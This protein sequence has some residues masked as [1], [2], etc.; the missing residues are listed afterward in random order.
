M[1]QR[2]DRQGD[3]I[4]YLENEMQR[5]ES[6]VGEMSQFLTAQKEK[7]E[8]EKLCSAAD[9]T[10][11]QDRGVVG[12]PHRK[13]G[14]TGFGAYQYG[15][16]SA[17]FKENMMKAA[18]LLPIHDITDGRHIIWGSDGKPGE[19]GGVELRFPEKVNLK[20]F[21]ISCKP[22]SCDNGMYHIKQ[23]SSLEYWDGFVWKPASLMFVTHVD[24]SWAGTHAGEEY[25]QHWRLSLQYKRGVPGDPVAV[26]ELSIPE[27]CKQSA[28]AEG[29]Y[30]YGSL[31]ADRGHADLFDG[32]HLLWGADG[33]SY[34][35]GTAEPG[36][37]ELRF[38]E[39]VSVKGF[40]MHCVQDE[41][42]GGC[43]LGGEYD[44]N[45]GK[46]QYWS[47]AEKRWVDALSLTK[48]THG[49][50][51]GVNTVEAMSR[52]WRWILDYNQH[53]V[54]SQNG[55]KRV[56]ISELE[57]LQACYETA[58]TEVIPEDQVC[59]GVDPFRFTYV[60][61][62][63]YSDKLGITTG[64]YKYGSL[65]ADSG[66]DAIFDGRHVMWGADGTG[67]YRSEAGKP[68]G[69]E[70]RFPFP[71]TVKGF[72]MHC[73]QD[74]STEGGGCAGGG[75]YDFN[76]GSLQYW[77][78]E[79]WQDAVV[80]EGRTRGNWE[81]AYDGGAM[82]KNWR[83]FMPHNQHTIDGQKNYAH[84]HIAELEITEACARKEDLTKAEIEKEICSGND[85]FAFKYV[86]VV[87]AFDKQA[88]ITSGSY[89]YGV[90]ASDNGRE[91]LYDGHHIMWGND[92]E[93]PLH[94]G[95]TGSPN[96]VEVRFPRPVSVTQFAMHCLQ[97]GDA[98]TTKHPG[99][100]A[101][102]GRYDFTHAEFQYFDKR[103]S[104]W[105][106]VDE[107][108][109]N[110]Y[111][112]WEGRY[113]GEKT[114]RNW[115]WKIPYNP[116]YQFNPMQ[117][118]FLS[119]L[120]L[121]KTC[122]RPRGNAATDKDNCRAI[123]P[124]DFTYLGVVGH[125]NKQVGITQPFSYGALSADHGA[126]MI[127]DGRHLMFGS[128]DKAGYVG[129][130][131]QPGGVEIRFQEPTTIR[132]FVM[133]C[134]K[135]ETSKDGSCAK[136]G[137]FDFKVGFLQYWDENRNRWREALHHEGKT[138]GNWEGAYLGT[139]KSKNWRWYLPHNQHSSGGV[140]VSGVHVSELEITKACVARLPNELLSLAFPP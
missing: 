30:K 84:V 34:V 10:A 58:I 96:G 67:G 98:S 57:V 110:D 19:P 100:F 85:P 46:L 101:S 102:R 112:N 3:R 54:G 122:R 51:L 99:C 21:K 127:F 116:G 28:S 14:L 134:I 68:G 59:G 4:S 106:T 97:N 90:L 13:L 38:P 12:K 69:V 53:N 130:R 74:K 61:V 129:A 39:P 23:G 62:V 25:S 80:H 77:D 109:T 17:T 27:L 88:G 22:G 83:W 137:G 5:T 64:G 31:S 35:G 138:Y 44:F 24:G 126:D 78:G 49:D 93:G 16:L 42:A 55:D 119:E 26:S 20:T 18:A 45:S 125:E 118:I 63:G 65:S 95:V 73:I 82:S 43:M 56:H 133:H 115:R 89:K 86:G 75:Q 91:D 117:S 114:S 104:I 36:G 47:K 66:H 131:G 41:A 94:D 15:T 76:R 9:M 107:I 1:E 132:G 79:R 87:H 128:D 103:A 92:M 124:Y 6:V 48:R 121:I 33:G 50:W 52:N 8:R 123:D 135:D 139:A 105:V 120:D 136:D 70:L 111:G 72:M 2:I 108:T 40:I 7:E 29:G 140:A 60:G 37:V 32:R 81:D 11:F 113:V 71:T